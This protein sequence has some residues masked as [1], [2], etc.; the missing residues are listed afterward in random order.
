[1][2]TAGYASSMRKVLR[3]AKEPMS[4]ADIMEEAAIEDRA[5][6]NVILGQR[7]LAGEFV[8]HTDKSGE[9]T[10]SLNANR[11]AR[12]SKK[13][14]AT[15]PAKRAVAKKAAKAKKTPKAKKVP[16]P[17]KVTKRQAKHLVAT[18]ASAP[19]TAISPGA[20]PPGFITQVGAAIE[21]LETAFSTAIDANVEQAV[22]KDLFA[23]YTATRRAYGNLL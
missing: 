15:K 22:L 20:L 5:G 13:A 8:R 6:A 10:Y 2:S 16:K 14:G 17:R 11:P 18:A 9:V 4:L 23:A 1:M 19:D 12:A 21:A 7:V 3:G